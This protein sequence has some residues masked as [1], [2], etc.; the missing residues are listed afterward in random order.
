MQGTGLGGGNLEA[1]LGKLNVVGRLTFPDRKDDLNYLGKQLV[2]VLPQYSQ[3]LR[4]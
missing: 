3:S 1:V 4:V 2:A